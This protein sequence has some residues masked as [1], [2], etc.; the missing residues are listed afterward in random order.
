MCFAIIDKIRSV[1]YSNIETGMDR[2][3][4]FMGYMDDESFL[5]IAH[6]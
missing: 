3:A 4:S 6:F 2:T 1:K 5:Q